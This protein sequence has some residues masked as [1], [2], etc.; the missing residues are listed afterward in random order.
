MSALTWVKPVVG[1]RV[2]PRT[3]TVT[4]AVADFVVSATAV[5]VTVTV[6]GL[7]RTVL[8]KAV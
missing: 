5:A 3:G 1:I 4:A 2:T 8:L 6:T 7:F